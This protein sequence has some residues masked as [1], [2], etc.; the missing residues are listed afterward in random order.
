M[1]TQPWTKYYPPAAL[2]K[3]DVSHGRLP[4]LL[5]SAARKFSK[6][7]AVTSPYESWTYQQLETEA[8]RLAELF[9]KFGI[10]S[11]SRVAIYL[12]NMPHYVAALFATWLVDATVAQVNPAY[13]GAEVKRILEHSGASLLV[14][15]E[16][17]LDKIRDSAAA[18]TLAVCIVGDG[19]VPFIQDAA[20][21]NESHHTW[22]DA[23]PDLAVLQYTGG[24]TGL[25]KA[26]MLTHANLLSNIEQRM[27]V[28]FRTLD[29][30]QGSKVV[31]T[32][33]MCHVFGLTCV[34][35]M[36]ISIGL[37]QLIVPRFQ[38]RVV[39]ELIQN[40]RP[41]AFFGV[42]T[43]YTAFLREPDLESFGLNHVLV[44][45]SSG[46]QLSLEQL[47]QF[48]SRVGAKIMDGFGMSEASP[49]THTNPPFL[50]RKNGSA[51]I[52]IP[53]TDARIVNADAELLVNGQ[54]N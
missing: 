27:R 11:G 34:T 37:N 18:A 52:P 17:Q 38:A 49:T 31:N 26:V 46:A 28:T 16:A 35:L 10:A 48:E 15:T 47:A 24:T 42:P 23:S 14:T 8:H 41:I 39:L 4:D 29:V 53:F 33:P 6:L 54:L 43:M 9:R 2:E 40:E 22:P 1:S 3:L 19:P 5:S 50:P 25:P 12:P 36:S 30:P 7:T 13:V 20:A 21:A 45:N 32:L 51:G 44:F